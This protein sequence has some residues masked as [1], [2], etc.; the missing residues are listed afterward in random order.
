MSPCVLALGWPCVLLVP[1][2]AM[3]PQRLVQSFPDL[4]EIC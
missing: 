2:K 1:R 3:V 4:Y